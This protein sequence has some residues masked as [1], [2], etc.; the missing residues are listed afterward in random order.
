MT[1][2]QLA[3]ALLGNNAAVLLGI[4]LVGLWLLWTYDQ[5]VEEANEDRA[6]L[7]RQTATPQ[8]LAAA[9]RERW[10]VL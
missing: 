5:L 1:R 3:D 7:D 9:M 2:E 6:Q 8:G 10:K 4:V